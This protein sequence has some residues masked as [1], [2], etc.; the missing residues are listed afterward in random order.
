MQSVLTNLEPEIE[1]ISD[2]LFEIGKLYLNK[3]N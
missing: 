1:K 3:T 2:E